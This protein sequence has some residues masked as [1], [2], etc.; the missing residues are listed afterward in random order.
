MH[1]HLQPMEKLQSKTGDF[2]PKKILSSKLQ[3]EVSIAKRLV[4]SVRYG[5]II[6][7]YVFENLKQ[8]KYLEK[9]LLPGKEEMIC[10]NSLKTNGYNEWK[11]FFF[12]LIIDICLIYS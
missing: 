5:K 10:N 1:Q 9:F 2:D 11:I 8:H 7:S 12:P 3:L 6:D 4:C